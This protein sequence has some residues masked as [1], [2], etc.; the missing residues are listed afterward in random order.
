PSGDHGSAD[1]G[2][3]AAR[4]RR[5]DPRWSDVAD[6]P[7]RQ[8]DA[9]PAPAAPADLYP[10][11][12][13]GNGVSSRGLGPLEDYHPGD[14]GPGRSSGRAHLRPVPSGSNGIAHRGWVPRRGSV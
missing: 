9:D 4:G 10:G 1:R 12:G 6:T 13:S 3:E 14:T 11:D 8:W 2:E 5:P 7:E